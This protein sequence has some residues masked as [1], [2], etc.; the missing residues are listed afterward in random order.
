M[1]SSERGG[2]AHH[3]GEDDADLLNNF[4]DAEHSQEQHLDQRVRMDPAVWNVPQVLV[5]WFVLVWHQ[6]QEKTLH[7]LYKRGGGGEGRG[8]EGGERE[9]GRGE[10]GGGERR[11]EGRRR[12]GKRREEGRRGGGEE[13][14]RGGGEEGRR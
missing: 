8:K 13:G 11:E 4:E 2:T 10:K 9:G 3:D 6:Q 7:K 5:V 1:R 14:R 12:E